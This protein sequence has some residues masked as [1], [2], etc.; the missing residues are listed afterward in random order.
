MTPGGARGAW[1]AL[2]FALGCSP[3]ATELVI[4]VDT[5]LQVPGELD[6]VEVSVVGPSG[7]VVLAGA[8]VVSTGTLP[9]TLGAVPAEGAALGPV[10]V[11]VTGRVMGRAVVDRTVRTAFVAGERRVL[12]ILLLGACR[13]VQCPADQSCGPDRCA[14]VAVPGA[15]LPAFTG[16]VSR[17][18]GGR[19]DARDAAAPGDAIDA[20]ALADAA[21]D[22]G[23]Q[24]DGAGFDLAPEVSTRDAPT[25]DRPDA[26]AADH[27]T[28][29]ATADTGAG[30]SSGAP[31]PGGLQ[32]C[33]GACVA[34]SSSVE[35]CGACG[36][37]CVLPG[38]TAEC[39]DGRC[40]VAA[41][42]MGFGDCDR[43][44]GNGCEAG[45]N[46]VA[47]C[48][49][50]GTS[51]PSRPHAAPVCRS[52]GC[53]LSCEVGFG[54]C[55]R[56]PLDGCEVNLQTDASHCGACGF[57]CETLAYAPGSCSVGTCRTICT[58]GRGD[59]DGN[60]SN[61]CETDLAT[62]IVHCG[63]CGNRCPTGACVAGLCEGE[64]DVGAGGINACARRP[65]GDVL[66][67]GSNVSGQVGN[68]RTS[69]S[70]TTPASVVGLTDAVEVGCGLRFCCARRA[71]GRVSCWGEN[72]RSQLGVG[73][74]AREQ[75]T[76][77]DVTGLTDAL[78]ISMGDSFACAR[79]VG[80]TVVC[81][82]DNGGGR[83][84]DGT[85]TRREAPV[86]VVGLP[87]GVVQVSAGSLHACARTGSGRVWCWG[88]NT[89]GQVGDGTMTDRWGAVA[90]EGLSDA[91]SVVAGYAGTCAVRIG[92]GVSCWGENSTGSVGDGTRERRL[93]PAAVAGLVD[94]RGVTVN[95]AYAC[96]LRAGGTVVCW[97]NNGNT[98]GLGFGG[99]SVLAPG[100]PVVGL[101]DAV[102]ITGGL[103]FACAR[104][105]TGALVCWGRGPSGE[106]GNGSN[107]DAS[108]PATVVGLP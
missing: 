88:T 70:Q 9:M 39:V 40:A 71:S 106:I 83:L 57:A 21:A 107:W 61:G 86:P 18:D 54:D 46:S 52:T 66:C 75:T 73:G 53:G 50:C 100:D 77:V 7:R 108:I 48:G 10:T 87:G 20:A 90:V 4:V 85:T 27:P 74:M 1:W 89:N 94:A 55:N 31:C 51:C 93:V 37:R 22:A 3:A 82:G 42:D 23:P 58:P 56:D 38:A 84:G 96:A 62:A 99:P 28:A 91:V 45:L 60:P 80:A 104:R 105:R 76:P 78:S 13:G 5:D 8:S 32:C 33:D 24:R 26:P 59:C 67:W 19:G 95:G 44:G 79:R 98:L 103:S 6:R 43:V 36:G 12:P 102:A 97:G 92:G 11:N 2:L 34:T 25:A 63:R 16:A 65:S 41:C 30:C 72:T 17:I 68:G 35:H 69:T 14:P 64:V 101:T 29:D 15:S 81:W 47:R 49:A